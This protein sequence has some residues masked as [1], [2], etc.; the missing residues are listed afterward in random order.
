MNRFSLEAKVGLL[1]LACLAIAAYVWFK[2]LE[3]SFQEGFLLKAQ[4]RSVEGLVPGAQVQIAGI[5]VGSVKDVLFD[6]EKSQAQV[7]MEIKDAYRN[8]IPE[9]SRVYIRTKGLLGDKF[10]VIEPG[11]PNAR[12]LKP[13]ETIKMAVEPTDTEKVFETIGVVA[14]DLQVLTREARRQ[15]IDEKGAQKIDRIVTNADASFGD[16]REILARNKEKINATVDNTDSLTKGLKEIVARNKD[17]INRTMDNTDSATKGLNEIVAK[18][19]ERINR[20]IDDL[21]RVTRDVRE[22]RGTLGK[23]VNDEALY[24]DTHGLVRDLRG[25]SGSIQSGRGAVGRLINDPELYFEARRA[26]RN[27]NKTAEDVS[28]ATPISTLAIILGSVFK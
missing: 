23:L 4:F 9:D 11:R 1:F 21:E 5:K 18:N 7:L 3:V 15:L 17:K 2:V 8:L 28:E 20:T 27:M 24:R 19:K 26:I 25:I 16:V 13:G 6:S 22:G 10:L 14:Q 12:K